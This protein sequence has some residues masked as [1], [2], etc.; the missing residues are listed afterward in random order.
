MRGVQ[1]CE[2]LL[3]VTQTSV[4]SM[5]LAAGTSA[6]VTTALMPIVIRKLKQL[7]RL[8]R[9]NAR[10]SHVTPTPRGGGL[11]CLAGIFAGVGVARTAG[12]PVSTTA[13]GGTLILASIGY[14]DDRLGLSASV[15]LGGQVL[16]GAISGALYG[17]TLAAASVGAIVVPAVVNSFN[18]MDGVNGI[19]AGQV[20][21]WSGSAL[22][23]LLRSGAFEEIALV[24]ST[25]GA[26]LTFLPWNTPNARVFLGDIGSYMFGSVI[27][28]VGFSVSIRDLGLVPVI[29]APYL[30]YL[31]D[32]GWT[33]ARRA[34]AGERLTD[35]HRSHVYQRLS[36]LRGVQHW[37]V[38][39]GV[40]GASA[41]CALLSRKVCSSVGIPFLV[42]AYLSSPS[43]VSKSRTLAGSFGFGVR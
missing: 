1:R 23:V 30:I 27:A 17:R 38:A 10:S 15:R 43:V 12:M 18:F 29:M 14:A 24:A 35:P 37:H 28:L 42:A 39:A 32:T 20:V 25:L 5:I 31:A 3:F 4:G 19:S 2:K 16:V 22:P 33:L 21:V 13:V 7:D 41:L 6:I 26:G 36:D 40:S 9:P 11:A 8:D 34:R